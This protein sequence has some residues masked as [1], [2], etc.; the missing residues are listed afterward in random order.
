MGDS[1]LNR[2]MDHCTSTN[3]VEPIIHFADKFHLPRPKQ[4]PGATARFG[5][6]NQR[7]VTFIESSAA[8][9]LVHHRHHVGANGTALI[10]EIEPQPLL[11]RK[12]L[13]IGDQQAEVAEN[14]GRK[15]ARNELELRS[16]WRAIFKYLSY[17]RPLTFA[18]NRC[19]CM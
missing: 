11:R 8:Y 10:E 2:R 6:A 15:S 13:T 7:Q 17:L 14:D 4:K 3:V 19:D 18:G 12:P 9:R 1:I 16:C 5:N